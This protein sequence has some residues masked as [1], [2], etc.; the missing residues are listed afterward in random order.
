M[1]INLN[2]KYVDIKYLNLTPLKGLCPEFFSI[3]YIWYRIFPSFFL[4]Q[5][6][7]TEFEI[8]AL[9]N[10]HKNSY[11]GMKKLFLL[12]VHYLLLQPRKVCRA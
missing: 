2:L 5:C 8:Y 1:W 12:Y 3:Y 4:F 10:E 7:N 9:T 11:S 6:L